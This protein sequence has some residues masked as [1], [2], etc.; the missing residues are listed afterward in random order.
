MAPRTPRRPD[1]LELAEILEEQHRYASMEIWLTRL[2]LDKDLAKT[3]V[4]KYGSEKAYTIMVRAMMEPAY[5]MEDIGENYRNSRNAIAYFLQED[6][7]AEIVAKAT[8]EKEEVPSSPLSSRPDK[9]SFDQQEILEQTTTNNQSETN[10]DTTVEPEK[11][12]ESKDQ[13]INSASSPINTDENISSD[14]ISEE[15]TTFD[16]IELEPIANDKNEEN[17]KITQTQRPNKFKQRIDKIKQ[18]AQ[19]SIN[20]VKAAIKKKKDAIFAKKNK[21]NATASQPPLST[22]IQTNTSTIFSKNSPYNIA[23]EENAESFNQKVDKTIASKN[24][25]DYTIAEKQFWQQQESLAHQD[26]AFPALKEKFNKKI[27]AQKAER[28]ALAQQQKLANQLIKSGKIAYDNLPDRPAASKAELLDTAYTYYS[29]FESK[30]YITTL[31]YKGNPTFGSGHLIMLYDE[32]N[33]EK[34]MNNYKSNYVKLANKTSLSATELENQFDFM[35]TELKKAK[36]YQ[37]QHPSASLEEA[38]KHTNLKASKIPGAGYN[39]A[40]PQVAKVKLT[41]D[42][43]RKIFNTDIE[44]AYRS[45]QRAIGKATFDNLTLPTQLAVM[46]TAYNRGNADCFKGKTTEEEIVAKIPNSKNKARNKLT[47]V[48]RTRNNLPQLGETIIVKRKQQQ[49]NSYA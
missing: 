8:S 49:K 27:S 45:C 25:E 17:T 29:H 44:Y 34:I 33:N 42:D 12:E 4:Q 3:M 46:Y 47:N 24:S 19:N 5:L 11:A 28:E 15:Q 41:E 43:M 13:Q 22:P 30:S 35:R 18:N 48:A 26:N 37:K 9:T 6:I 40:A 2:N 32:V 20:K 14:P 31:D 21:A 39:I 38:L 10:Q 36:S 23:A 7:P 1:L 16:D